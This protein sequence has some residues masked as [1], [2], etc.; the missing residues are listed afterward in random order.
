MIRMT[1]GNDKWLLTSQTELARLAGIIAAS[2]NFKDQRPHEDITRAIMHSAD[3]W[4]AFDTMPTLSPDNEVSQGF[5][6]ITDIEL[7]QVNLESVELRYQEG[8]YYGALILSLYFEDLTT[9]IPLHKASVKTVQQLGI[10]LS[11]LRN[12]RALAAHALQSDTFET[13]K[14]QIKSDTEFV[15]VCLEIAKNICSDC[16]VNCQLSNLPYLPQDFQQITIIKKIGSLSAVINPLPFKKNLRDHLSS[17]VVPIS[18]TNEDEL[19]DIINNTK[20]VT[21]EVHFGSGNN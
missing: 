16:T 9:R 7:F 2:W 14:S 21:N 15:S 12:I 17:W 8:Q 5:F 4:K 20:P 19:T 11:K 18:V 6:L 13:N 3:G 1:W 10:Y